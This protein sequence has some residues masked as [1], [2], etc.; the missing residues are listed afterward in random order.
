MLIAS[1]VIVVVANLGDDPNFYGAESWH[2]PT[3]ADLT[4]CATMARDLNQSFDYLQAQGLNSD[5]QS[6]SATCDVIVSE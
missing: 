6:K 2:G 5:W 4:Q 3:T 1:L